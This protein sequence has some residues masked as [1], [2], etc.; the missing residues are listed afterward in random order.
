MLVVLD[1]AANAADAANAEQITDMLPASGTCAVVVLRIGVLDDRDV[2][3]M[4]SA[5][6]G[7]ARL[8]A[9]PAAVC[10]LLDLCA[11]FRSRTEGPDNG[12]RASFSS[13]TN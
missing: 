5:R 12:V 3:A 7:E 8:A 2:R 6:S 4:L 10:H 11:A 13:R 9:D 1:N